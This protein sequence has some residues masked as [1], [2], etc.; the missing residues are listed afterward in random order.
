ML[1]YFTVHAQVLLLSAGYVHRKTPLSLGK[2]MRAGAYLS[3]VSNRLATSSPR[4]R[5]LG[6]IVGEA[7]SGLVD[8]GDNKMDFKIEE[9]NTQEANWYKSL[10]MVSDTVGSLDVLRSGRAMKPLEKERILSTRPPARPQSV[11][12][13]LKV[14]CHRG[15]R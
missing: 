5:L 7:L 6:M 10:V 8:T 15:S 2:M 11:Q 3:L 13:G 14:N 12:T 4:A 9:T 1:S